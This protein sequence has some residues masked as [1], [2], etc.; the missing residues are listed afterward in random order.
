MMIMAGLRDV[1]FGFRQIIPDGTY[2]VLKADVN[3]FNGHAYVALTIKTSDTSYDVSLNTLCMKVF[4]VPNDGNPI[5]CN[6]LGSFNKELS[7][8]VAK[9]AGKGTVTCGDVADGLTKAFKGSKI[10]L[11]NESHTVLTY[12]GGTVARTFYSLN[13]V[14]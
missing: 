4:P 13:R 12:E 9:I 10:T 5:M 8:E 1:E 11:K 3:E 14:K 6:Q 2:E 7:E